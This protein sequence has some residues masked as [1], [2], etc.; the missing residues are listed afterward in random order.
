MVVAAAAAPSDVAPSKNS[1]VPVGATAPIALTEAVSVTGEPRTAG[2]AGERAIV[3]VVVAAAG[4]VTVKLAETDVD[5]LKAAGSVGVKVAAY[6]WAPTRG[7]KVLV[8][9]PGTS[10]A[11]REVGPSKNSKVPD[12]LA[13][14]TDA[15]SVKGVPD[16]WGLAGERPSMV[17]VVAAGAGMLTV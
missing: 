5:A 15:L 3:V 14:V 7:V 13:G 6:E 12:V 8:A 17:A 9:P 2:L 4:A 11:P 10:G 1:K 16:T